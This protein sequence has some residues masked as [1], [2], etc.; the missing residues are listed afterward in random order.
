MAERRR[1]LL[2]RVDGLGDAIACVPA[3]EA[4]RRACDGAE[5][6][7]VCSPRNA[8][9]FDRGRVHQVFVVRSDDDEARVAAAVREA[10]FTDALVATEEPIGYR[11]AREAR[12]G[13]RAGFWHRLEKPLKSLWQR[14]LLTEAVYRPAAWVSRPEH[15]AV[16]MFALAARLGATAPIPDDP[17]SLRR[18]MDVGDADPAID[19]DAIAFQIAT[20]SQRGGWA[21]ADLAD[22]VGEV[23]RRSSLPRGVLLCAETDAGLA[24]AVM[25]R[26]PEDLASAGRVA[27]APPT[28]MRSWLGSI[29]AA[30]AVVTPDTGAAHAAGMLGVPV[31]DLFDRERFAQLSRQ[32]RPWAAPSRCL[33]KPERD[34][35]SARTLARDVADALAEIF[36]PSGERR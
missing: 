3:L 12:I 10:G 32:W 23:V 7:A 20:K 21:P 17:A 6:G 18:W 16:A 15:E 28:T 14:A 25:E 30:G 4:L 5:F 36:A 11:I 31:V 19:R 24:S 34:D 26:I 27:L 35:A 33:I 22:L 29:A 1:F 13:R 2:I 8:E 9:L